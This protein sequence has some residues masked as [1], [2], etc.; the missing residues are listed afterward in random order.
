MSTESNTLFNTFFRRQSMWLAFMVPVIIHTISTLHFYYPI[1]PQIP[2]RFRTWD[3]LSEK[4]WNV[5]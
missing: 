4:P 3:I 2:L 1:F 5:I